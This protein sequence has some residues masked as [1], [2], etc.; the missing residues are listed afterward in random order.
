M[1]LIFTALLLNVDPVAVLNLTFHENVAETEAKISEYER[2]N[3]DSI[4]R[5]RAAKVLV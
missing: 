4:A 2:V 1:Y 5:N 3:Q